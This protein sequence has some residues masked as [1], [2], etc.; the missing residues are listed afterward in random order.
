MQIGR[1]FEIVYLLMERGTVTAGDLAE[2]FE[3]STRTI[4]RDIDALSGAGIPVYASKGKGGGIRLLPDFVLNKSLL[5]ES[6]QNEILF[7]LQSLKATN[8]EGGEVLSRLSG[9][10]RRESV[11]WI[12]VDFSRWGGGAAERE[13]YGMIKSG[14]L[15]RRELEFEYY[16]SYGQ[17]SHRK[18]EPVKLRF[19]GGGW[20]LQAFCLEKKAFRTFKICR[21]ENV[22]LN[23]Q[24]FDSLKV[25]PDL[26]A[27]SNLPQVELVKLELLISEAMGFR[28]FDEFDQEGIVRTE[29]GDFHVTMNLP[30]DVWIYGYLMSYGSNL[31]VLSPDW[32]REELQ[33]AAR[34]VLKMYDGDC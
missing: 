22:R 26:E 15:E 2:R 21:M 16:S 20:Y 14:I 10:F 1:L 3:V 25:P 11:D 23:G 31:R 17:K 9:L 24:R 6:E 34:Q 33:E 19:K 32:M 8:L 5:T 18:V 27:V 13:K 28:V 7:A 29:N 12:D 4:Y 30:I